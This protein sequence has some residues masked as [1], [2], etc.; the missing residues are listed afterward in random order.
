M[1]RATPLRRENE[2]L[3]ERWISRST[4]GGKALKLDASIQPGVSH[5]FR[6]SALAVFTAAISAVFSLGVA[7]S[8]RAQTE[9]DHPP[10]PR[11]APLKPVEMEGELPP[12]REGV[13]VFGGNRDTGLE[14]VKQLVARGEK[15]TVMVRPSSDR[16][17]LEKLGVTMVEGDAMKPEEAAKAAATAYYKAAISTL[18]GKAPKDGPAVD[19]EGNRNVIDGAKAAGIPRFLLVTTIGTGTSRAAAPLPARFFLRKILPLKEQAENYLIASGLKY[20]IIRPG[21]LL[22]RPAEGKAVLTQDP[23]KFGW[24]I[25]ADLGKLVADALYDESNAN[26]ILTAYDPTRD[27]FFSGMM[28]RFDENKDEKK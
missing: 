10:P 19:F 22:K 17:E 2:G 23:E 7:S 26:K 14:V 12:P 28:D 15:V 13:I 16:T 20:T 8:A 5:M 24:I 11:A 25:R 18:G 3:F 9:G 27:S 4:P 21:G 1:P 6:R